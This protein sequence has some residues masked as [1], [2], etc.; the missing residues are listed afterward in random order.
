MNAF[1]EVYVI[2]LKEIVGVVLPQDRCRLFSS[3]SY[4][5][6]QFPQASGGVVLIGLL[7][8]WAGSPGCAQAQP[9]V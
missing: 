4:D 2:R 1:V 8:G 3:L 5:F 7:I 9:Y 6:P